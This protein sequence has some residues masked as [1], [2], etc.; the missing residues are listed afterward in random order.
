MSAVDARG[1]R[2]LA[3]EVAREAAALA[4]EMRLGGIDVA[5]T[6][7]SALDVVTDADRASEVLIR[8]RLLEARPDDAILGEEG[9]DHAG[10]SG[11]RWIVDP[12]DGTVNYLYGLP[13]CAVSVAAEVPGP[14][15]TRVV[16]AGAV[17]GIGTTV[18]YAAARGA[19]ATRDGR[20]LA[21]RPTPPVAEHLVLTGF[22]YR[23]EVKAHQVERMTRLLPRVRDI[24]R[25]GSCALDLCHV[26]EGSADAYVE[27]GPQLW[28][29]AAASL[30]LEEAGGRFG[31][32]A[33]ALRESVPDAPERA[34]LVGTP[35]AGW[36][37]FVAVLA[38]TGFL[39]RT[40]R[41]GGE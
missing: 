41:P 12:I 28:D 36:D 17:V 9:D 6:K 7:S 35:A 20:P 3:V 18:E 25:I 5:D 32:L 39:A 8:R 13:E 30:V 38:E 33:G 22:G 34:L 11:V 24:R 14:D 37:S 10:T 26:A 19:G 29:W 16:A 21:V 2:D 31:V 40:T 4:R 27:E 1:L 15:G 23:T